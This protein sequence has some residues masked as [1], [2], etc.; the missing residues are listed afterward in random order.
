MITHMKRTGVIIV[1]GAS[2][3][4]GRACALYLDRLGFQVIA[5]VRREEDA[6]ELRAAASE[7][8]STLL[9]DITNT[10][11][12]NATV[13][14]VSA[15]IGDAGIAGLV[16][17]AGIA[18]AGPLEFLPVAEL[19]KQLEVNLIGQLAVTQAF[20]PLLRKGKGRIVNVGSLSGKIAMPFVGPYSATKF[21]LE[22]LSDSL[23]IELRPWRIPVSLIEPGFIATPI[24]EK[25]NV[26]A[27]DLFKTLPAQA[28][29]LYGRVIPKIRARYASLGKGGT[30]PEAVAKCVAHALTSKRPKT[31]YTVGRGAAAGSLILARLPDRLRDTL[32]SW[33]LLR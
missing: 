18:V 20:L 31:R 24:W 13:G 25:S 4:I 9:L 23:R 16:N 6:A 7:R 1:T 17:N 11:S 19:R 32:I 21:A 10:A 30:P 3:G 33:W 8:L 14:E 2:T 12:I 26:I 5:S 15:R 28:E 29:H 22:S 27:Y